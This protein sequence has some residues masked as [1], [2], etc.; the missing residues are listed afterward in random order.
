MARQ[1][2]G[3]RYERSAERET[4]TES[5]RWR[6]LAIGAALSLCLTS[7]ALADGMAKFETLIKPQLP[8]GSLTYKSG[9]GLGDNGF[10]LEGV[11]VTPPPDSPSGKTEPIAIKKLSVE[12]FDFTAFEKQ[13]PPTFAKVRVEGI[14]ISD[15]PA[16]GIDLKQMAGIDK[17][18]ADF[19][20]DYRLEPER[21]TLTLNKLEIDLSGLAR[22]ELSMILDGVSPD[23]AGDPDAA[24]NDATLRTA[25]LVF[26]DRSILAKVVPAI[27]QMQGG[28][29][30]ATLLIAKTMMAPLRAGQGP[31]A[32]AAFDAIESFVDDYK[33]PKG[34]LKVTLNP[35]GK[36]SA[37]ALNSAAGADDVIKAL[38]MDVSYSGTV[39]HPVP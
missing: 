21:K 32:Q 39:P 23:I 30:A 14:A 11:V 3:K 22:L 20:L 35:P 13:T 9:K 7:P 19:Q 27:A 33:K 8:E 37:T 16:E 18:N 17:I 12:D 2:R 15:K 31:K 5:V 28:D 36:V 25:T 6:G 24:M 29:A 4:M 1:R 26:E 10:V 34:P 38:G